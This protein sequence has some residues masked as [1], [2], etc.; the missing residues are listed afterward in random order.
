MRGKE[1]S[2]IIEIGKVY[3]VT[4]D[5]PVCARLAVLTELGLERRLVP[6]LSPSCWFSASQ[7]S[8]VSKH[9]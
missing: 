1:L 6:P 5:A 8:I 2:G 7:H 4:A 3:L 9:F